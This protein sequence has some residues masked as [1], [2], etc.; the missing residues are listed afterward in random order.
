MIITDEYN[1][2]S[3]IM[4]NKI[5]EVCVN[6]IYSK[7]TSME[8][9]TELKKCMFCQCVIGESVFSPCGHRCACYKCAMSYFESQKHCPKCNE[10][11][12]A[13]CR[14]VFD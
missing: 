2:P 4:N 9:S 8:Q 3:I 5:A 1:N 14:K 11:S 6:T 13:I 10:P 12:R 7:E